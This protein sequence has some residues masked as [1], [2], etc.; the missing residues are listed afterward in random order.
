[1]SNNQKDGILTGISHSGCKFSK[2][3]LRNVV[4]K[5]FYNV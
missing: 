5:S 4:R 2:N 3:M 1:M